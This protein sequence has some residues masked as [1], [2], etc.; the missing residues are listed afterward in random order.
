MT[1]ADSVFCDRPLP[2]IGPSCCNLTR[3]EGDLSGVPFIRALITFTR[4]LPSWPNH[5]PKAPSW[6]HHLGDWG[7]NIWIWS[8]DG[9][10]TNWWQ[11]PNVT[12]EQDFK[13]EATAPHPA[14]PAPSHR[15]YPSYSVGG[16]D[17]AL[18]LHTEN[19]WNLEK[20][21]PPFDRLELR[22]PHEVKYIVICFKNMLCVTLVYIK[23]EYSL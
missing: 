4:A 12:W 23:R 5:S 16:D 18:G 14:A 11:S 8:I 17:K 1:P 6:Y 15:Y 3:G 7:F 21:G 2:H 22:N 20:A 13:L 10:S 9:D 19:V